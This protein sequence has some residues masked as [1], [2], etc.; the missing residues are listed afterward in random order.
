MSRKILVTYATR[1]GST[2]EVA[3]LIAQILVAHA[4]DVDVIPAKNVQEIAEYQAVVVGS[5]VRFGQWLPEAVQFVQR[6]QAALS[7]VPV[8]YFT[9]HL[10][11]L[12]SDEAARKARLAYLD[13]ARTLVAPRTEAFFAGSG[14]PKRLS[15]FEV[16]IGRVVRSPQDDLRDWAAIRAWAESL[17]AVL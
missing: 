17:P 11:N 1:A 3:E 9:V 8:A 16:L 6:H 15:F 10:M 7:R 13:P 12:G 5:A 2:A 4:A 14:D